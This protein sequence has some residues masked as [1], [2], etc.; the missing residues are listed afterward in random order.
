MISLVARFGALKHTLGKSLTLSTFTALCLVPAADAGP[1]VER[2]KG[3]FCEGKS[4][5]IGYLSLRARG[6]NEEMAAD[7]INKSIARF[8]CAYYI[9]A[10]AIRTGDH[11]VIEDGLVFRLQSYLFLP[12]R[13]ERWSG[14]VLGAMSQSHTSELDL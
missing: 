2:V 4:D 6:E 10:D 1:A 14:T 7:A 3:Y 11:T 12:E 9:P 5:Q 13:V 8:S